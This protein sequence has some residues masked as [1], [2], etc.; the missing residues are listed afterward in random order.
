M[1]GTYF[2]PS[3]A[4][5]TTASFVAIACGT[6]PH[7]LLQIH[8]GDSATG[9]A[10]VIRWGISFDASAAA[11]PGIVELFASTAACTAMAAHAATSIIDL[12]AHAH[13]HDPNTDNNPFAYGT[14]E[15]AYSDG[16]VTEG[17][18]AN[19]RMLD[20]QHIAPTNQYIMPFS[21]PY[22]EFDPDDFLRVRV[23]MS[24][25][26]NAICYIVVEV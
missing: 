1:A 2:I 15:T 8:L 21:P 17:T 9:T 10:K 11:T 12:N 26:V 14:G 6:D 4:A 7:T 24:A 25:A 5:P 3:G 16:T 18:P 23:H 20:V 13:R 22:P 19:L